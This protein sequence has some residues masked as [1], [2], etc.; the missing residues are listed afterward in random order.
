MDNKVYLWPDGDVTT[1][2]EQ[3]NT[4]PANEHK[5]VAAIPD[6]NCHDMVNEEITVEEFRESLDNQDIA[7][8]VDEAWDEFIRDID[9]DIMMQES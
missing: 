5:L 2:W 7:D 3:P 4:W 8:Q 6:Y 9:Y 1:A